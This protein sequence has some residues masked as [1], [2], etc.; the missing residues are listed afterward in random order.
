MEQQAKRRSSPLVTLE[1]IE[2][3][4]RE[5][6]ALAKMGGFE[7]GRRVEIEFRDS[8]YVTCVCDLCTDSR[9][10]QSKRLDVKEAAAEILIDAVIGHELLCAIELGGD[11]KEALEV[12]QKRLRKIQALAEALLQ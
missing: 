9:A 1:G 2:K 7:D 5:R 6:D 12:T 4:N 8:D 10:A 11:M 3:A